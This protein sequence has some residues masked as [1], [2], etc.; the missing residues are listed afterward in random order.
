MNWK[1]GAIIGCL[2]GVA[3]V[4]LVPWACPYITYDLHGLAGS[5][6]FC[7][8]LWYPAT[9]VVTLTLG[10][11][12]TVGIPFET[13]QPSMIATIIALPFIIIFTLGGACFGRF[14]QK[15][16]VEQQSL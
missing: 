4:L 14:L 7:R 16:R 2:V 12:Y 5:S 11:L 6:T 9:V 13:M 8:V 10:L 1:K 15:R 3:L